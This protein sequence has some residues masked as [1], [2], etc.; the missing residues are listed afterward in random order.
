MLM[1][2]LIPADF[3]SCLFTFY[4]KGK[5]QGGVGCISP[6]LESKAQKRGFVCSHECFLYLVKIATH[7]HREKGA[8]VPAMP[9][10]VCNSQRASWA[11]PRGPGLSIQ[12]YDPVGK[13]QHYYW[14]YGHSFIWL[15]FI[16]NIR[17]LLFLQM[18][19]PQFCRF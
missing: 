3:M 7:Q 4:S 17:L 1:L 19:V 15:S 6:K 10:S 13:N 14:F 12:K 8:D 16:T 2:T 5:V 18:S 9:S 11:G